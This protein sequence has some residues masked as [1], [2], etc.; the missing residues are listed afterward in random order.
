[1]VVDDSALVRTQLKRA[2]DAAG[3]TVINAIDG[4]DAWKQ[5]EAGAEPKLMICDVN[6]PRMN[7]LE[8]L[9]R[10]AESGRLARI[11]VLMLTTQG[12]PELIHK[13]RATGAKAWIIKPFKPDL[14]V[15]AAQRL[16]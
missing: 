14:I 6:M 12:Q 7:G 3:F 1:M 4:E 11:S 9:E 2:L 5:L 13:A 15:A 10:M 16:V 8:L